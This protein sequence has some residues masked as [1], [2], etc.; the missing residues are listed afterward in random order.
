MVV[1]VVVQV[2]VVFVVVVVVNNVVNVVVVDHDRSLTYLLIHILCTMY[3][4][5][6]KK[7]IRT[8]PSSPTWSKLLAIF[9]VTREFYFKPESFWPSFK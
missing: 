3:S 7:M 1:A 2:V 8:L 4:L 9:T 6:R 5:L